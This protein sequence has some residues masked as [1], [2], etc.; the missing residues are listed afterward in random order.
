M[1]KIRIIEHSKLCVSRTRGERVFN[2]VISPL[3]SENESVTIDFTGLEA[4]STSFFDEVAINT[5]KAGKLEAI[6][7][8]NQK[9]YDSFHRTLSYLDMPENAIKVH[10]M[11]VA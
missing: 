3:I 8:D 4:V 9:V 6:I 5:H 10:F 1:N 11:E 2:E 7:I